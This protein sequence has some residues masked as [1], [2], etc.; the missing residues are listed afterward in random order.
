MSAFDV[1]QCRRAVTLLSMRRATGVNK[2]PL[3]TEVAGGWW[4]FFGVLAEEGV[5]N[6]GA[7]LCR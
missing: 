6:R 1:S 4:V 3:Y 5:P 7:F 2:P